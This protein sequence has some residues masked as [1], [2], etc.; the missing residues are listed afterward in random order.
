MN[1]ELELT[2]KILQNVYF[3]GA[4]ASIELNKNY[5]SNINFNLVTKI[6]YGVIDADVKLDYFIKQFYK[7]APKKEVSLIFKIGAYVGQEI[8]SIPKFA[9]VNELVEIAKHTKLKPYVSFINAVLKKIVNSTFVMPEFEDKLLFLSIKYSKPAW[10]I[11]LMLKNFDYPFVVSFLSA[12]LSNQT[13]I[14]INNL[15]ISNDDF[16]S[17]LTEL[18]IAYT[19]SVF[20]D[21]VFVDYSN[22]VRESSL[23]GLYTP[24]GIPSMIVSRNV[25]GEQ[26]LDACSAPGGKAIYVASL[27]PKS[28]VVACDFYDH[29]VKLIEDYA[30]RMSVTNVKTKLQDASI[31]NPEFENKFDCVLL[32][33]PCSGLG[34]IDKKPDL[35]INNELDF[36]SLPLLQSK[37]LAN[38]AKYVKVGGSIVYS[39]CTILPSENENIINEFLNTHHNFKLEY[40]DTFG[41]I[42]SDNC[43]LKTFY[44]HLSKTEGFF[45]GKLVRYE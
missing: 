20:D 18:N 13:H 35:L 17:R 22:I 16:K 32:D 25:Q 2:Y 41:V 28:S 27:N 37:M 36:L 9:L 1:K 38:N 43:G 24:Q 7:K 19:S 6:T 39:T 11:D 14:R 8:N 29:R 15:K 21:A 4:Y 23:N 5:K 10:F 12:E 33:V 44:P 40:V 31:F 3:K 45:I 30:T 34:V 26:V 42:C